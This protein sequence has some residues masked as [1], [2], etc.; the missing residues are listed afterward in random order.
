MDPS[1]PATRLRGL[2]SN[3]NILNNTIKDKMDVIQ[4]KNETDP[5]EGHSTPKGKRKK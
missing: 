4:E 3:E 5:S 1:S 2:A